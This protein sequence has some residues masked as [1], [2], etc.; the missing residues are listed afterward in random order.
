[1]NTP[2]LVRTARLAKTVKALVL[3][4]PDLPPKVRSELANV[5]TATRL[6]VEVD[7]E[8]RATEATQRLDVIMDELEPEV[9]TA[10]TQLIHQQATHLRK[11]LAHEGGAS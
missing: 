8:A 1:M 6:L 11:A 7:V 3:L 2:A 10:W 9:G 5:A 4:H